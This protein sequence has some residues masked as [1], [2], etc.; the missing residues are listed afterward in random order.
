MHRSVMCDVSIILYN[1]TY[2]LPLSPVR[3]DHDGHDPCAESDRGHL[4]QP[5]VSRSVIIPK[6][7]IPS[8]QSSL[9]GIESILYT[10]DRI[11]G[12]LF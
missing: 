12:S 7:P 4:P 5:S 1:M 6:S 10:D 2:K 9:D 8:P 3:L 11:I